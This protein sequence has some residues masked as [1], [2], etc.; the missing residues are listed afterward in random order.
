[1]S[2]GRPYPTRF[3]YP[4]DALPMREPLAWPDG[5]RLAFAV[6]VSAEY[7][8][9]APPSGS[10]QPPNLPGGFGRGPYP[11]F[12]AFSMREYGNRI[13]F[14][15][16]AEVLDGLGLRA[17]LAADA[18]VA[19]H[20][21]SVIRHAADS[22]WEIAA[23]G[24][25]VTEVIS[26]RMSEDEEIRYLETC[27]AA[28]SQATGRRPDGWHG[29]EYGE[30]ERTP[31]LLARAGLDYLL[32]WTNDE[33]PYLLQTPD[34]DLASVP[35]AIDLDDVFAHWHRKIAMDRWARAVIEAVDCLLADGARHGRCLVLNLHPWLIGQPWRIGYLRDV[36]TEIAR[37]DGIW[38][39]TTGEIAT[40]Y[41]AA[42][43]RSAST[44]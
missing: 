24:L 17:T 27:L 12:R 30:S 16:V 33:Q 31:A 36:L 23:H 42:V 3:D 7:Y 2:E 41:R 9:M 11:D 21:P 20:R 5:N 44:S 39:A 34:G 1:M 29:A 6:L 14:F 43:S 8:Q 13:G 15:R 10:F 19:R 25:A 18:H 38:H 4:R 22:D 26:S 40:H 28:L 32:D 37:R 35:V